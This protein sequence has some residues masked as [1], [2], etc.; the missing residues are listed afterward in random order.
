MPAKIGAVLA[1]A[2]AATVGAADVATAASRYVPDPVEFSAAVPRRSFTDAG[3]SRTVTTPVVRPGKR[4]N[5]VGLRW[6]G[7]PI[8]RLTLRTRRNR[9]SWSRWVAVATGSDDGPDRA[10]REA[11]RTTRS[12]DPVWAGQADQ[13]Q[14]RI[15]GARGARALRLSFV[16]TTG[17]ATALDR[18]ETRV[19]RLGAT[20]ADTSQPAIVPRAAWAS[21]KCPPRA[22]PDYGD[23]QIAFIHHTVSTNSYGPEDSAA[24][25]LGICRYHRNTNGWNDIGYNFL[26]DRYGTIFEGRAGGIGE[27]VVGAQA[28]GYNTVSTGIASL[29]T[30]STEGQTPAGLAAIARLLSWKL[31]VHGI[32]PTGRV[33]VTSAGGSTNRYPAGSRP[34]FERISGHRDGDATAC[35]GDG[36]Y[37]QL[38]TLRAMIS[39]G[40]PRAGTSTNAAR[41]RRNIPYGSKAVL[42]MSLAA[43]PSPLG[44]RP[45]DVQVL[46]SSGWRTS[47]TVRTDGGG[48]AITRMRLSINRKVRARFGGA[49]GLLPSSSPAL[50]F[51]VRPL[52][53]A[54]VGAA[55]RQSFA[56]RSLVPITAKVQPRKAAAIVTV[57]RRTAAGALVRV[58]RRTTKLRRGKLATA[59]RF[60]RTGAYRLR[61]SVRPDSRNLSARSK[62]I[63]FRVE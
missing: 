24:M 52:V 21:D 46:G 17:T 44:D 56:R 33:Q 36:L 51:G 2:V 61:V 63:S 19:R 55:G 54:A 35:P 34:T 11:R 30:F 8:E 59:M 58:V 60:R 32:P 31:A 18:M 25:V 37:A 3:A 4:F 29:G 27:A 14:A 41:E 13:V 26:V 6:R 15:A 43:G 28:Q 5:V 50:A 53:T 49:S 62:S 1:V 45:I 47:H 57:K 7:G 42:R 16:N 9:G 38:P 40:P 23:V 12:S 20:A 48:N 39:P 10:T 22:A